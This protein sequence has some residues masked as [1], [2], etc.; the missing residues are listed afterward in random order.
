MIKKIQNDAGVRIQFKQGQEPARHQGSPC[1]ASFCIALLLLDQQDTLC[2]S[3]M[4]QPRE[5]VGDRQTWQV[6]E[7]CVFLFC[8]IIPFVSPIKGLS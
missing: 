1:Q 4:G 5:K 8:Q 6:E 3:S 7:E 2:S